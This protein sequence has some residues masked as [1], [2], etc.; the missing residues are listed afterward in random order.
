MGLRVSVG[1]GVVVIVGDSVGGKG[2]LD[3]VG[4]FVSTTTVFVFVGVLLDGILVLV[5]VMVAGW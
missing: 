4:V 1:S 5:C 2:V 3:G